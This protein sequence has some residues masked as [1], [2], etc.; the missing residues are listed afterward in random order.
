MPPFAV[1]RYN[2]FSPQFVD[3]D[4]REYA[5]ASDTDDGYAVMAARGSIDMHGHARYV[6][7]L[8]S[9]DFLAGRASA[10][11]FGPQL[12][13]TR[14][15]TRQHGMSDLKFPRNIVTGGQLRLRHLETGQ[16]FL[17]QYKTILRTGKNAKTGYFLSFNFRTAPRADD[18][19]L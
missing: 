14:L 19:V 7:K 10:D 3:D 2:T 16:P 17:I 1:P 13:Y 8:R 9:G 4:G 12:F 18:D 6:A 5:L 15:P 11:E